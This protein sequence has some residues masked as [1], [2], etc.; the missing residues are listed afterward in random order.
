MLWDEV[1]GVVG[2]GVGCG[3]V[4]G[5]GDVC[6]G[7]VEGVVGVDAEGCEGVGGWGW[8]DG[9]G[10]AVWFCCVAHCVVTGEVLGIGAM[11]W[12]G[13]GDVPTV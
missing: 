8:S 10:R 13:G 5:G 7:G 3:G 1:V 6:G 2:V 11:R 4:E 9:I 12:R